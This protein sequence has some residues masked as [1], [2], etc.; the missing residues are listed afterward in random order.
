MNVARQL[1]L[2]LALAAA[3]LLA[4]APA[5]LAHSE[6]RTSQP[7]EGARLAL[8]PA[9]IELRFNEPVQLTAL[10]LVDAAGR[11]T[12]IALPADTTPRAVERLPAPPL[13]PGAWRIEWRAISADGH[14]VRGTVRFSIQART[15]P[16]R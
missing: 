1:A 11:R 15:E 6:L 16:A 10:A 2:R 8:P 4:G 3:A 12:R 13:A 7:A 14:P 5:A 9:T